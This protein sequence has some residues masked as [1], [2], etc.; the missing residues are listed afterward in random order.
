MGYIKR[1]VVRNG[2]RLVACW[3]CYIFMWEEISNPF[4]NDKILKGNVKNILVIG[5]RCV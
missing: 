5:V 2:L 4:R 3:V 1:A